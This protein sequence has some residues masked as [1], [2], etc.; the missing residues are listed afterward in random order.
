[1]MNKDLNIHISEL[2]SANTQLLRCHT[3]VEI[4]NTM[5]WIRIIELDLEI[6]KAENQHNISESNFL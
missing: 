6:V 5:T 3:D 4:E 2:E 1:M